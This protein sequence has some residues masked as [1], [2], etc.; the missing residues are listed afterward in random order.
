MAR[1][2]ITSGSKFETLAAYSRAVAD[3][4]FVFVSGTV[5][6]DPATGAL[7]ESAAEQVRFALATIGVALAQAGA[8]LSDIVHYRLYLSD[9]AYLNEVIPVIADIFR[10][11]RPA[12]TT[13][14]CGIPVP[15]AK[16]EIEAQAKRSPNAS[17]SNAATSLA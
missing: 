3:G 16:V 2:L 17:I 10:D 8:S 13:L 14:I 6:I 15:G 12:N 7:P 5:G 4:D 11:I 1:Q 9:V